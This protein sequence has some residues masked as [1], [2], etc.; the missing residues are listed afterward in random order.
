MFIKIMQELEL[1]L[2][3]QSNDKTKGVPIISPSKRG[4]PLGPAYRSIPKVSN[5][6]LPDSKVVEFLRVL[7][8]YKQDCLKT[9]KFHEAKEAR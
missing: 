3:Q 1:K 4:Y 7:A 9:S 6:F 5:N 2:S 8:E